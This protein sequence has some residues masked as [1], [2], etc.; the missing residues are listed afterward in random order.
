M[1]TCNRR[2]PVSGYGD[3]VFGPKCIRAAG[4]RVVRGG[5]RKLLDHVDCFPSQP[6]W[7]YRL[8]TSVLD[9]KIPVAAPVSQPLSLPARPFLQSSLSCFPLPSRSCWPPC[10]PLS[11]LLS[12]PFVRPF[13][14]IGRKRCNGWTRSSKFEI[15]FFLDV[16]L[17]PFFSAS[18]IRRARLRANTYCERAGA[19][20]VSGRPWKSTLYFKDPTVHSEIER[21][22]NEGTPI[23]LQNS[24]TNGY[25]STICLTMINYQPRLVIT[26]FSR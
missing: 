2:C 16:E 5:W 9:V 11:V 20:Q 17:Y 6:K 19:A 26:S 24:T 3:D 7:T 4:G 23:L 8:E 25:V 21:S 15:P 18:S 10:H 12:G 1:K 22:R 13:V 14:C